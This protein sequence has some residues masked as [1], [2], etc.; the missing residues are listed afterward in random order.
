MALLVDLGGT[1]RGGDWITVNIDNG[2]AHAAPDIV[3]DIRAAAD[4]LRIYFDPGSIDRIRLRHTLEHLP[5]HE[6]KDNLIYWRS[7][8]KKN[9]VIEIVVPDMAAICNRYAHGHIPGHIAA[10]MLYVPPEWQMRGPGEGHRWG[11]DFPML[12]QALIE[13]GFLSVYGMECP[14]T[15]YVEDYPVPNLCVLGS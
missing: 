4:E 12:S 1:G 3:A 14:V 15:H 2:A 7:F 5:P 10:G 6:L 11:F 9:G 8:L 13:A